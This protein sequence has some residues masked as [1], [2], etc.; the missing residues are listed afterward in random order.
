MK[1]KKI[2][3]FLLLN[4]TL[5]FAQNFTVVEKNI[6][7]YARPEDK[8]G[9]STSIFQNRIAAGVPYDGVIDSSGMIIPRSGAVYLYELNSQDSV[10]SVLEIRPNNA[11][12]DDQFGSVVILFD[13]L[14]FVSALL[15]DRDANNDF[16]ISA[17]GA[18]FVFKR[19]PD[20]SW[21]Q[22]QKIVAQYRSSFDL[23]GYSLAAFGN[24]LAVGV[25]FHD[26]NPWGANSLKDAGAVYIFERNAQGLYV[27]SQIIAANQRIENGKFGSSLALF[28]NTLV[29]GAAGFSTNQNE[30]DTLEDAGAAYVFNKNQTGEWQFAQK[31]VPNVRYP[32]VRFGFACALSG[33]NLL[34]G[35]PFDYK[36][37]PQ[38]DSL[39]DAGS[40][41]HYYSLDNDS[42]EFREKVIPFDRHSGAQF[43]YS[44]AISG[45]FSLIGS[46]GNT[47]SPS[48]GQSLAQSGALHSFLSSGNNLNFQGK[49]VSSDIGLND[50]FGHTVSISGNRAVTS[51]PNDRRF[52][53]TDSV[54][55]NRLGAIY[56]L[57]LNPP[58]QVHEPLAPSIH[59]YPNPF[60]NRLNISGLA[61]NEGRIEV[62]IRNMQGAIVWL[63]SQLPAIEAIE[64]ELQELKP[65][66]YILEF[67][68][69]KSHF[70]AKCIKL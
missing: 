33:N 15:H 27:Q 50:W 12:A 51:S 14:L 32:K 48:G 70:T 67:H 58:S 31:L 53:Y 11:I 46:P 3:V 1:M 35:S 65:G 17:A 25:P 6:H 9:S 49:V 21:T 38:S 37:T 23:F 36:A 20:N 8:L 13:S 22:I 19:N 52:N 10:Q 61:E 5:T 64:L 47:Y 39:F 18:V 41:Y 29:V 30:Q 43:G 60:R 54:Y 55:E 45:S 40:A 44:L 24:V 2:L 34:I 57:S 66:L 28:N 7:P 42:F 16:F 68:S 26:R 69:D 62:I 63:S 4:S 56:T 59:V